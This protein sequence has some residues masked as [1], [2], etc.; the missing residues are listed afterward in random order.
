METQ[1]NGGGEYLALVVRLDTGDD[2]QWRLVVDGVGDDGTIAFRL[3]PAIFTVRLWRAAGTGALRGS[4]RLQT[5]EGWGEHE[6]PLHS[7]GQLEVLA[8]AW[9]LAA[10]RG[11]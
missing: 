6:A 10:E 2:G 5:G 3:A 11:G 8:R 4:V 7:N 9:L 1:P